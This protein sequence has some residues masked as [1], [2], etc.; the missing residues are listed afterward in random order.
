MKS[1]ESRFW[2]KVDKCRST[3]FYNGTRC[4]EWTRATNKSGYGLFRFR[5]T[6]AHRVAWIL[7]NGS[8]SDN[9]RV[10][11]H[12]DNRACV[13]P[14][15]LFIGTQADNVA[16]AIEKGRFRDSKGESNNAA[17]LT[18]TDIIEIR[19]KYST[20][21]YR[22]IDLSSEYGVSIAAIGKITTRK[23]WRHI[24]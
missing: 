23:T 10:L 14:S 6:L 24:K 19:S 4:W 8:V 11:H 1:V 21:K 9:I 2:E 7:T 5:P 12:C 22:L 15:H 20:G 3:V 17:I 16:D 18:D 13:N